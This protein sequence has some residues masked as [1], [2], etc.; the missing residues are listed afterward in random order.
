MTRKVPPPGAGGRAWGGGSVEH[1]LSPSRGQRGVPAGERSQQHR[2]G[3]CGLVLDFFSLKKASL[4]GR[5]RFVG[6]LLFG[7]WGFGFDLGLVFFLRKAR[8]LSGCDGRCCRTPW[9]EPCWRAAQVC[10]RPLAG[11]AVGPERRGRGAVPQYSAYLT[12]RVQ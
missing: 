11:S 5:E 2:A 10:W 7:F 12:P 4:Y 6:F 3:V 8:L 1:L 9:G